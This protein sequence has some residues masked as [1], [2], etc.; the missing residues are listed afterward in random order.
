[1]ENKPVTFE[2]GLVMAG[3]VSAGAYTAGVVDYIIEVLDTWHQA[4]KP[5]TDVPI[6][7]LKIRV[8][9]GASAGGMTA[10]ISIAELL[11]RPIMPD[12]M[13]PPDYKSLLYRTWVEDSTSP[14]HLTR[15][16]LLNMTISNLYLIQRL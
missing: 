7:D 9:T 12:G 13:V 14:N 15:Q 3:A 11:N 8:L 5:G 2:I 6:H 10:A 16:T 4:R 1:M